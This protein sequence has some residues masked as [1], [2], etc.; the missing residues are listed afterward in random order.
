MAEQ[1]QLNHASFDVRADYL[2]EQLYAEN[3]PVYVFV[4]PLVADPFTGLPE[5]ADRSLKRI[6]L[7]NYGLQ[8]EQQPY[9]FKLTS[10]TDD[11]LEASLALAEQQALAESPT[12]NL[13]GW[14]Q[15]ELS[16]HEIATRLFRSMVHHLPDGRRWLFRFFDP[17]VACR[18]PGIVGNTWKPAGIH[19]WCWHDGKGLRHI[20]GDAQAT[21]AAPPTETQRAAIDRLGIVNQAL[22]QWRQLQ[23]E[24]P[25]HACEQLDEAA[26]RALALGLPAANE[27]D[28]V[29]F[30]LHRCLVHPRI[31]NHPAVKCWIAAARTGTHSYVDAAADANETLWRNIETGAWEANTKEIQ[32]G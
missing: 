25:A 23:Q 4:D 26:K 7:R 24:L 17:R 9:F 5:M 19:R 20:A 1:R 27:A 11:I 18:L 14:F 13:C 21:S 6:A 30:A 15:S 16:V 3:L 8:S 12:R 29:A 31:E 32:H 2:R 28:C 10:S 22:A